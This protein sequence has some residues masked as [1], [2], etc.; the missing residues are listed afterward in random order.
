MFHPVSFR[1]KQTNWVRKDSK[2]TNW[3]LPW[4]LWEV[5]LTL[6]GSCPNPNWKSPLTL[7]EVTLTYIL[8]TIMHKFIVV[9]WIKSVF[10]SDNFCHFHFLIWAQ[11]FRNF[12]LLSKQFLIGYWPSNLTMIGKKFLAVEVF[13][14][15]KKWLL[16]IWNLILAV[17]SVRT[18][19]NCKL[20]CVVRIVVDFILHHTESRL[21]GHRKYAP[22]FII[23]FVYSIWISCRQLRSAFQLRQFW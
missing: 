1:Y 12:D 11:E 4:P 3:K 14:V 22:P 8:P 16:K 21:N 9:V 13:W 20:G 10:V 5:T 2:A 6:I 18:E 15:T 17:K 7:L 19:T 23:Q